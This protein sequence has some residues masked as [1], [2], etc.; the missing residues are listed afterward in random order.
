MTYRNAVHRMAGIS[1]LSI[2]WSVYV[3]YKHTVLSFVD[4]KMVTGHALNL[5]E[6][7]I[8]LYS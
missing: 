1:L 5:E 3:E 7:N 6:G 2:N 4:A 8:G